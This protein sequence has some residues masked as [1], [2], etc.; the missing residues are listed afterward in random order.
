MHMHAEPIDGDS[1]PYS[2]LQTR[3]R[4]TT[5]A[6]DIDGTLMGVYSHERHSPEAFLIHDRHVDVPIWVPIAAVSSIHP[7]TEFIL[8]LDEAARDAEEASREAERPSS[9]YPDEAPEEFED[10]DDYEDEDP[11]VHEDDA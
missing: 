5:H 11:W 2:W 4:V 6:E 10:E 7:L 8:E 9:D 1:V 3:V